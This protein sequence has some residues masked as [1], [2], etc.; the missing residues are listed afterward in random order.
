M[1]KSGALV[2]PGNCRLFFF[3]LKP[4]A[5]SAKFSFRR[6]LFKFLIATAVLQ[7]KISTAPQMWN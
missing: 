6:Y 7:K 5:R 2:P 4:R 1:W 3:G